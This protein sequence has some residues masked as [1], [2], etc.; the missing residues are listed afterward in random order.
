MSLL[1][2]VLLH[3]LNRVECSALFIAPQTNEVAANLL[4]QVGQK[5][6]DIAT[7]LSIGN[8]ERMSDRHMLQVLHKVLAVMI[9]KDAVVVGDGIFGVVIPFVG[10]DRLNFHVLVVFFLNSELFASFLNNFSC[11]DANSNLLLIL[12]EVILHE[13]L[14]VFLVLLGVQVIVVRVFALEEFLASFA[15]QRLILLGFF[16]GTSSLNNSVLEF[17]G[18]D[19]RQLRDFALQIVPFNNKKKNYFSG[20]ILNFVNFSPVPIACEVNSLRVTITK[21]HGTS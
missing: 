4:S 21:Q 8:E 9:A 18:S 6:L 14:Q 16:V 19:G 7:E 5:S 15:E 20:G 13:R 11:W 17:L 2:H 12:I 10:V 1:N 3:A